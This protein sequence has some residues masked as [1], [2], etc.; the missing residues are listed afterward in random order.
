MALINIEN[1]KS[2]I[3]MQVKEVINSIIIMIFFRQ[4]NYVKKT[5]SVEIRI[6]P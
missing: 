5:N 1:Y 3:E 4:N 6:F 2:D